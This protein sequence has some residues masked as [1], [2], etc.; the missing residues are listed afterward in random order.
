[1]GEFISRREALTTLGKATAG[2]ALAGG[3]AAFQGETEIR[4]AGKPVEISVAAVSLVT[5]R[6]TILPIEDGQAHAVA[7][8]GTLVDEAQGHV[9]G[10]GRSA[11]QVAS[12]K[13]GN[14]GVRFTANPPTFRFN[15]ASGKPIQKL[16]LD[17]S[18]AGMSFLLS[19]GPV[20]GLGEG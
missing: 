11:A 7:S 8:T 19:K 4:V 14:I 12:L 16:T 2:I 3:G 9:V 10:H 5:V 18:T 20:L 1:M 15:D 13:A 17:A 6:I